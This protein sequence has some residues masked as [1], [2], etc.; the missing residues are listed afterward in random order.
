M[1]E[2]GRA[3]PTSIR[4]ERRPNEHDPDMIGPDFGDSIKVARYAFGL[5]MIPTIPP[6][7]RWS[8]VESESVTGGK[9]HRVF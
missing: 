5:K 2:M 1:V 3:D 8:V 9:M 6:F 7:L 4:L